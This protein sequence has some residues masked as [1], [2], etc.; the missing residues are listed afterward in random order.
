MDDFQDGKLLPD[1][2]IDNTRL[3]YPCPELRS[4][5][6]VYS[7]DHGV[8]GWMFGVKLLQP[9]ICDNLCGNFSCYNHQPN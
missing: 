7:H 1:S 9:N 4:I 8:M 3:I 5:A 6:V 2:I